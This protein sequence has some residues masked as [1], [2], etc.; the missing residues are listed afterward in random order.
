MTARSSPMPKIGVVSKHLHL[1]PCERRT[2]FG[3]RLFLDYSQPLEINALIPLTTS[4]QSA[5]WPLH[6]RRT[7]SETHTLTS[8][9]HRYSTFFCHF[10]WFRFAVPDRKLPYNPVDN[11]NHH[12]AGRH[13]R[14]DNSARWSGLILVALATNA[15]C[16]PCLTSLIFFHH[17]CSYLPNCSMCVFPRNQKV[18]VY[19]VQVTTCIFS[20]PLSYL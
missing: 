2:Q 4:R 12:R 1:T 11:S 17:C 18:P 10:F 15:T 7:Q 14:T 5:R 16:Y 9:M 3:F 6:R 20:W 19:D 8:A 13:T